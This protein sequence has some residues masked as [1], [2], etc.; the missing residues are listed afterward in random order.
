MTAAAL[1]ACILTPQRERRVAGDRTTVYGLMPPRITRSRIRNAAICP[2]IMFVS[3]FL[4][5]F[6]MFDN[7]RISIVEN[8]DK[9]VGDS[10]WVIPDCDCRASA[11][12]IYWSRP[13]TAVLLRR[14]KL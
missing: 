7:F 3:V 9:A 10:T 4:N 6:S 1:A 12:S 13:R 11:D 14:L 5:S 2:S 8:V